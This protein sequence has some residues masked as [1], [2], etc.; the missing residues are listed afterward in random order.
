MVLATVA[1]LIIGPDFPPIDEGGNDVQ[2]AEFRRNLIGSI[3]KKSYEW[4]ISRIAFDIKYSFGDNLG[5]RDLLKVWE[6]QPQL[7]VEF[8]AE[9]LECLKLGGQFKKH[10]GKTF[11]VAP[12]VFSAWPEEYDAFEHQAVV[13]VGAKVFAKPDD[14]LD[15]IA[16][17]SQT[18]V[19]FDLSETAEGWHWIEHEPDKWAWVRDRDLRSP[20]DFRAHFLKNHQDSYVLQSFL[21]GD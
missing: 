13:T 2:F 20:I 16:S 19:R 7:K 8:F 6:V 17:L 12:Y 21:A 5:K 3:E 14:S 1:L 15:P 4:A 9:L 11:F 10:D 18:I